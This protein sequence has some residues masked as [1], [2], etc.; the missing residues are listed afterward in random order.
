MGIRTYEKDHLKELAQ[1]VA[2]VT[3]VPAATDVAA[4]DPL[5]FW[6]SHETDPALVDLNVFKEGEHQRSIK[7]GLWSGPFAGRPA[8]TRELAPV[9]REL[10]AHLSARTVTQYL[11]SLRSWW[12]LFDAVE[13]VAA[14]AGCLLRPV[15]TVADIT[16]IHR[17]RAFDRGMNHFCFTNFIRMVNMVRKVRQLPQLY[18]NSPERPD[19]HRHLPPKWHIDKIRF[20]LKRGW[21]D[22]LHRWNR[23]DE[24][25]EGAEP[26]SEEESRLLTNYQRFQ[27]AVKSTRHPRPLAAEL[28]GDLSW[29]SFGARGYSITEML[30]GFYPDA[31]DIRMAFHVCL[32][33]TGWNPAVL[34]SLNVND[35]FIEPHPKDLTRYL[36]RGYKARGDSEPVTEG[37]FKSQGSAGVI[38]Q[39]LIKRTEPLRAQLRNELEN[40]QAEYALLQSQGVVTLTLDSKRKQIVDLERGL[41][42]PWLYA[43]STTDRIAWLDHH[44]RNYSLA[45]SSKRPFLEEL[46]DRINQKQP[47]DQKVS[48]LKAG[49]FRDAFAAYAYQVSGGMVLY[50]M[51][52]LGHKS[53]RTT[54]AYLDNTLLNGESDRLYGTFSNSLWQ[55]IKVHGR[56]DP[57]VIAKW[58]R[59]GS[60]T[61]DERERLNDYRSLRRSRI[62]VGCKGPTSP[63]KRIAPA[64]EA[65]GE[66]MCTNHRC[67]L[68]LEN[69]VIFPDS[70]D[71]LCKRLAELR[72]IKSQMPSIAFLESS[73]GEETENTELALAC[74]D[75]ER[76]RDLLADWEKRIASGEHRVIEFDGVQK[77]YA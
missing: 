47:A 25:M 56:V 53:P 36:M 13:A 1:P 59:D 42:S 8:L 19:T 40:L 60:V 2:A 54:Q 24:L 17:Q 10:V 45:P 4:N 32:A 67:T 22:A 11:H 20:A 58:S 77:S 63:P 44:S 21:F 49:D 48:P 41:R 37:L 52:V 31:Y 34:L 70:M 57:T 33:S 38:I 71:G 18:W 30:R 66:A 12:R 35:R 74:F 16:E 3:V 69:A 7:G 50:V 15:T 14:T 62:G 76:V 28:C 61:E 55:E 64:F 5:R 26:H 39:T 75:A 72:F 43:T 51:K 27:A 23:A 9:I 6:T 65:D 46:V 73:F 29:Y 68:C